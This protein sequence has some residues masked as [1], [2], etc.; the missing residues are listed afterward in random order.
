VRE[1]GGQYTHAAA[2]AVIACAQLGDGDRAAELL[3]LLNPIHHASTRAAVDRYKVEPYVA[4]ADVYSVSPHVGR[5]GWTWYTGAAAWMYRLGLESILGLRPM[6]TCFTMAP[7]IPAAWE[8]FR[9]DWNHG[10]CRYRIEVRNPDRRNRGVAFATLDG[11]PV[12]PN[13]IP[14]ASD[15]AEHTVLIVMGEPPRGVAGFVETA[16]AGSGSA[17]MFSAGAGISRDV[18]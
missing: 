11:T 13:V 1:N 6:G 17:A 16:R 5:G 12:N 3:S 15:G 2:W 8:G 4:C 14:L 7:C 10:G 18:R 9:V